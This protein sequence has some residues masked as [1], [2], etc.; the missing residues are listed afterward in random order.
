M[1]KNGHVIGNEF[2]L[3]NMSYYRVAHLEQFVL[4]MYIGIWHKKIPM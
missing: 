1:Y 4:F 2:V 3:G